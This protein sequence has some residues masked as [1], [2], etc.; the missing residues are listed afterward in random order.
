V[1]GEEQRA[2]G[3]SVELELGAR[4]HAEAVER[5]SRP[6]LHASALVQRLAGGLGGRCGGSGAVVGWWWALLASN[7]R[8]CPRGACPWASSSTAS[9]CALL[10]TMRGSDERLRE[11]IAEVKPR[12]RRPCGLPCL[13]GARGLL[14]ERRGGRRK[15]PST[16]RLGSAGGRGR[17]SLGRVVRKDGWRLGLGHREMPGL[18]CGR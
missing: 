13:D 6:R 7:G 8:Q 12:C 14:L 3:L 10:D 4:G 18:L 1:L 17:G 15:G 11:G 16:A 9:S 5:V 2:R